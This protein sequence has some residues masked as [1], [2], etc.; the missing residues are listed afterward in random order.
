MACRKERLRGL[1]AAYYRERGWSPE[2]VPLPETLSRLG[3]WEFLGEE[4]RALLLRLTPQ[5]VAAD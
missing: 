1:I 4:A 3:L 5:P 2:G